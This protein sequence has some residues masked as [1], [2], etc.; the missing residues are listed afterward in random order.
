LGSVYEDWI[1]ETGKQPELFLLLA[2]LVTFGF[3]RTSAHLIRAQVKWWPG[4]V[5]VGG[6][7]VHHLVWGILLLLA[8]GYTAIAIGPGHPGREILAVLFGIGTGLTL[9][10]F[11]L[12][13]NLE[14]VYWS[15][16][17]RRSIDAVIIAAGL[18]GVVLV[19]LRAWL[20]VADEAEV[21]LRAAIGSAVVVRLVLSLVNAVK[22]KYLNGALGI[23]LPIVGVISAFRLAKP[24]SL[25]AKGYGPAKLEKAAERYGV[26]RRTPISQA[27][28]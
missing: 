7:H 4:N 13:L 20:S 6:T 26:G 16:K 1:V 27:S 8:T 23:V 17:G 22:G 21:L 12:W 5:S 3:I 19:G 28:V 15:E 11:A 14:D 25:W 2:F 10:E 24:N 9:D 18:A